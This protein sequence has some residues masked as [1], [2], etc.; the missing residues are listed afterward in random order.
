MTW[1]TVLVCGVYAIIGIVGLLAF[2]LLL[3]G[4]AILQDKQDYIDEDDQ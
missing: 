3:R 2:I 4:S 1:W